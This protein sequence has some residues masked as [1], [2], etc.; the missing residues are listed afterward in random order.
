MCPGIVGNP[1]IPEDKFPNPR[2]YEFLRQS[3]ESALEL[4]PNDVFEALFG[5]AAGGGKSIGVLLAASQMAHLYGGSST[6]I[7]RRT[8]PE[9]EQEG[10]LLAHARKWWG[11]VPGASFNENLHKW[12]FP[13]GSVVAFGYHHHRSHD[14]KYHGGEY[15][16][17]VFDELS[18]WPDNH[19]WL[20]L[21]SRMRRPADSGWP[22][23][24]LATSN[25]GGPGHQWVKERFVGGLNQE[26]GERIIP[27]YPY[28]PSLLADNP[29]VDVQAYR[30]TL[31]HLRPARMEQ[32]LNGDWDAREPGDYFQAEWFGPLI[33]PKDKWPTGMCVRVRSWDL[34]ASTDASA[35]ETAGVLMARSVRGARV[36][37]DCKSFRLVPGARDARILQIAKMDGPTV[38]Q[39]FEVEPGSGGQAQVDNLVNRIKRGVGCKV[40]WARP[41]AEQTDKEAKHVLANPEHAKGKTGRAE[42]ASACVYRGHVRRGEAPVDPNNPDPEHGADYGRGPVD[43]RDGIMLMAGP[44]TEAFLLDHEL[45]PVTAEGNS[46]KILRADKVDAMVGA[47]KYTEAH[48]PGTGGVPSA[49]PEYEEDDDLDDDERV[50][51]G[52]WVH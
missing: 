3:L 33:D 50:E 28:F 17:V 15:Q 12:T 14:S 20:H 47:Y 46:T 37:E 44:W 13:N 21:R 5:G 42:P 2:Q 26:T 36:V 51:S 49:P 11:E 34:A 19:A 8:M 30:R 52:H 25:P 7:L 6:V 45:F 38:V 22:L 24:L 48:P 9:L 40:S 31:S 43:Q 18:F 4:D 10:G 32:L 23:R 16:L 39:H 35:S 1:L 41:K 27:D 29:K